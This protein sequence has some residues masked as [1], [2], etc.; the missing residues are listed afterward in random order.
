MSTTP[1]TT[2]FLLGAISLLIAVSLAGPAP[3]GIT[4][5]WRMESDTD[6]GSQVIVPNEVGGS[7]LDTTSNASIETLN[8]GGV[9]FFPTLPNGTPNASG[10]NG[11][12]NINGQIADYPGLNVT[13]G[14]VEFFARTNEGDARFL[15]RQ[16]G[17]TG[18]RVD[19]PN[20][21]RVEYSTPAGQVSVSGLNNF[22][23]NWDHVALTYNEVSGIGR[24]YLNGTQ[25]GYNDG[26]DN[27]PL[28]WPGGAALQVGEGMDGGSGFSGNSD[29]FFDEL[30]ISDTAL[31][32]YQLLTGNGVMP[33][34]F[35]PLAEYKFT[36][37]TLGTTDSDPMVV[38]TDI[39]IGPGLPT[40][41][42]EG[43]YPDPPALRVGPNSTT[44]AQAL[45]N[46]SFFEFTVE[47]VD[48][49]A[50]YLDELTFGAARG[51]GGTPRGW[52]LYS[53]V[54][55]F[56]L[57]DAIASA[58]NVP[59]VRPT[60]TPYAVD[61]SDNRFQ[62]LTDPITFRFYVATPSSGSTLEFDD[63]IL[64]GAVGAATVP[65]PSTLALALLGLMAWGFCGRRRR[66]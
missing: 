31:A 61:L 51:G 35:R 50:L 9:S 17:S 60:L 57:G 38:P 45:A 40:Q 28:T 18:L 56:N 3:A 23:A 6:A 16:S 37:N 21:L 1:K 13:S 29:P 5:Y 63:I 26:P 53:S 58:L 55:G 54:D 24:V 15:L 42:F 41:T 44:E 30:R 36:G 8:G 4:G 12:A 64:T 19:Q 7:A 27:Q 25:I 48:D 2:R 10:I 43:A 20:S 46:D 66:R 47:A 33:T 62:S 22:D 34:G 49:L 32:P 14:T 59:T 39:T 52:F 65:E 11:S